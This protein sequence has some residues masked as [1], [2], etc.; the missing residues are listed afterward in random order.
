MSHTTTIH[1]TTTSEE[2][3]IEWLVIFIYLMTSFIITFIAFHLFILIYGKLYN[4][5]NIETFSCIG[6]VIINYYSYFVPIRE[7]RLRQRLINR[8][9]YIK[10]KVVK[11]IH[12]TNIES[13]PQ[14]NCSICLQEITGKFGLIKCGHKFHASCISTWLIDEFKYTCPICRRDVVSEYNSEESVV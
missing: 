4:H 14:M 11:V 1:S 10:K 13:T 7:V 2:N 9:N 12:P 6:K 3:N 8:R 5:H